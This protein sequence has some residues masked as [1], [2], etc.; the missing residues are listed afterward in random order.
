MSVISCNEIWENRKGDE[1]ADGDAKSYTRVWRVIT[2]NALD[3]KQTVFLDTIGQ[4]PGLGDTYATE[5]EVDT[6]VSVKSRQAVQDNEDPRVWIVTIEYDEKDLTPLTAPLDVSWDT[7]TKRVAMTED[8]FGDAILNSA[9]E[10]FDPPPEEE[11]YLEKL[12]ITKNL[13]TYPDFSAYRGK[14]NLNTFYGRAPQTV[15]LTSTK[16]QKQ[17][18]G[19]LEYY[20]ATFEFVYDPDGWVFAPLDQ[21]YKELGVNDL[22]DEV[23]RQI[24]DVYGHPTTKPWLLDGAGHAQANPTPASAVYLAYDVVGIADFDDLGLE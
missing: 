24:L 18:D 22:A 19:G 7:T 16:G 14:M 11:V 13:A 4:I 1:K 9:G 6:D 10:A 20:R 17:N 2:N 8:I 21:G 3:G 23:L 15:K 5:V 12:T